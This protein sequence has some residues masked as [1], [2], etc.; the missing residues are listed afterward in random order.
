[1]KCVFV[2]KGKQQKQKQSHKNSQKPTKTHKNPQTLPKHDDRDR[3]HDD[4]EGVDG[5]HAPGRDVPVEG[6]RFRR[7]GG[8]GAAGG[9][10]GDRAEDVVGEGEGVDD[11]HAEVGAEGEDEL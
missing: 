8:D 2:E 10:A 7:G 1:M 6:V 11:P 5:Y 4:A 3:E 9:E